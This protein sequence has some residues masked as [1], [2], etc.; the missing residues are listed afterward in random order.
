MADTSISTSTALTKRPAPSS[1]MPPPPPPKRIKRPPKVL[2]ED[3]YTSALSHIIARDF[4]LDMLETEAQAD[5][6]DALDSRDADWIEDAGRK[7]VVA[8]T[9]RRGRGGVESPRVMGGLGDGVGG[10][11][12]VGSQT[13]GW[14]TPSRTPLRKEVRDPGKP[15]V[16]LNMSL[17]SFQAKY[18]SEDNESFNKVVDKQNVKRR[19]KQ[20]W[21]WTNNKLPSKQQIAQAAHQQRL[22]NPPN[23]QAS[24]PPD[25]SNA[26]ITWEQALATRPANIDQRPHNPRNNLMFTPD[27]L[28]TAHPTL[29]S[30]ADASANSSLAPLKAVNY[31]GTRL[32]APTTSASSIP[33]SPSISAIDAAIAGR[34][35]PGLRSTTGAS[36]A[37]PSEAGD[38]SETPRVGGYAFVDE[39]P[40]PSELGLPS[41]PTTTAAQTSSDTLLTQLIA[42]HS[43]GPNQFAIQPSSR[44]ESLHHQMVEK[45]AA[46]KRKP[47]LAPSSIA[48]SSYLT[49]G[50]QGKTPTPR[51]MSSPR[52]GSMP[53][54]PDGD[55]GRGMGNLTPAARMLWHS[56]GAKRARGAAGEE[57][58]GVGRDAEGGGKAWTPTP[59]RGIKRAV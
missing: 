49:D 1:L 50:K 17:A 3:T 59:V 40:T 32:Q 56:I 4:F 31:T 36:T 51:F 33:P 41:D 26:L 7:M 38:G 57:G 13:R 46:S 48:E 5:F 15:K 53:R 25:T 10:E 18:T 28:E 2:D 54:N 9:P 45:Q 22:L 19:E 43:T 16:D 55:K 23:S 29:Q 8:M 37:P 21:L 14:E 42:T 52:V 39:E 44:R 20:P 24:D 35:H 6:L 27:D 34:P 30:R 58:R 12:P 47:S 11:T